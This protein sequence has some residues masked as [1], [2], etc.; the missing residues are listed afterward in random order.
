MSLFDYKKKK[1]G[2]H[3]NFRLEIRD[4]QFYRRS[5]FINRQGE[6]KTKRNWNCLQFFIQVA[7]WLGCNAVEQIKMFFIKHMTKLSTVER[8]LSL[9]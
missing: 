2:E 3:T 4:V 7:I 1:R 6:V 9:D 8:Y 5:I